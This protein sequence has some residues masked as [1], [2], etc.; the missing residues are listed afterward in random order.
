MGFLLIQLLID[1]MYLYVFIL[2]FN[3]FILF[4]FSIVLFSSSTFSKYFPQHINSDSSAL[5][6]LQLQ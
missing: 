1:N 3:V 2:E 6:F 5:S 4:S